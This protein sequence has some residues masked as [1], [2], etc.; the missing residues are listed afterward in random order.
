MTG[1]MF[2]ERLT[3]NTNYFMKKNSSNSTHILQFDKYS[4]VPI[5]KG[6]EQH[7]RDQSNGKN[8]T[9]ENHDEDKKTWV[10]DYLNFS[11]PIP[12]D[13]NEALEDRDGRL[14][15]IIKFL[16]KCWINPSSGKACL[17][18]LNGKRC[19]IDGH[20]LNKQ[21]LIDL[22]VEGIDRAEKLLHQRTNGH[23]DFRLV[24]ICIERPSPNDKPWNVFPSMNNSSRIPGKRMVYVVPELYNK[25]G[26]SDFSAFF[27]IRKLSELAKTNLKTKL[28]TVDTDL[29]IFTLAYY[30]RWFYLIQDVKSYHLEQKIDRIKRLDL[31]DRKSFNAYKN[32]PQEYAYL[33]N[34]TIQYEPRQ[35]WQFYS[36]D[37][38]MSLVKSIDMK[39]LFIDI[40]ESNFFRVNSDQ[41]DQLII[42]TKENIYHKKESMMKHENGKDEQIDEEDTVIDIDKRSQVIDVDEDDA[43]LE[44]LSTSTR[45]ENDRIKRNYLFKHKIIPVILLWLIGGC[46]YNESIRF[47]THKSLWEAMN[48]WSAYIG[49]VITFDENET[50]TFD[51][52]VTL[53]A[54]AYTRLIKCAY[55]IAKCPK[56]KDDDPETV[57]VELISHQRQTKATNSKSLKPQPL[58]PLEKP[59][60]IN[61]IYG[62]ALYIVK[63]LFQVGNDE[64]II[65]GKPEDYG[66]AK[67]KLDKPWTKSNTRRIYC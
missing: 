19:I 48:K 17:D 35:S 59:D 1:S 40:S 44:Y 22:G 67:I 9:D 34:I 49:D 3:R 6:S 65:N 11:A 41:K 30:L 29:Q 28:F 2:A 38:N 8:K 24:P 26:E 16:T 31:N 4:F 58:S 42:K 20:N 5:T 61:K 60:L 66:Y 51:C 15:A 39:R 33:P 52:G 63:M 18:P 56:L 43:N 55:I 25:L 54:K 46:D 36:T 14:G 7:K 27:F 21:D 45:S 62:H 37:L 53:N 12:D 13:W 57:T 47:I 10:G 50:D 64:L 23:V 32:S